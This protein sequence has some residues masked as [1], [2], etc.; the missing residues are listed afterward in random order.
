MKTLANLKC[1]VTQV[2][3]VTVTV[4]NGQKVTSDKQVTDFTW[5]TQGHTFSHSA[6]ILNIPCYDLVLGMDWLEIHSPMWIHWK[7]KLLR[8]SYDGKRIA[9]KG[10]KDSLSKCPKIKVRKLKGLV[11][12]DSVAQM[13]HLCPITP[14]EPQDSIPPAVQ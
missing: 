3:P 7:R 13:I 1:A 11:R 2:A 6:R 4:A 12:K 5:W 14:D 9:L 10:T 8:F